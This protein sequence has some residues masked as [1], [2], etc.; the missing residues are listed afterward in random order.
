MV[1]IITL[2]KIRYRAKLIILKKTYLKWFLKNFAK[3]LN[4][5]KYYMN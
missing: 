4:F 2:M 5:I 1:F 3:Y